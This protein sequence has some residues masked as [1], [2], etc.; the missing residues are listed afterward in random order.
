M[1]SHQYEVYGELKWQLSCMIDRERNADVLWWALQ[2]GTSF[3]GIS[4]RGQVLPGLRVSFPNPLV[5][6][7]QISYPLH[8]WQFTGVIH[9]VLSFSLSCNTSQVPVLMFHFSCQN[10]SGIY[11]E[12]SGELTKMNARLLHFTDLL[13]FI[14]KKWTLWPFNVCPSKAESM[15]YA[16]YVWSQCIFMNFTV[17]SRTH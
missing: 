1:N 16:V 7:V 6:D 4:R 13:C 12:S 11:M 15:K 2:N 5:T 17:S 9:G 8:E 10:F 3:L 14:S